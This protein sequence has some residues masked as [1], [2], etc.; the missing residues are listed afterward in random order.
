MRKSGLFYPTLLLVCWTGLVVAGTY[1]LVETTV[2]QHLALNYAKVRGRIIQSK[3]GEGGSIRRGIE[4][5]YAYVV[6]GIHYTG[7]RFRYDDHNATFEWDVTVDGFP[8]RSFETVYYN[9]NNPADAVLMP[10]IEGNDCLL[11]L[12]ALPLN[13]MT[14][15]LWRALVGRWR[16]VYRV[17]PVGGVRVFKQP[18]VT[19]VA[20][21]EI[22]A[23]GAAVYS[24][25]AA[26][27]LGVFPAV[28]GGGFDPSLRMMGIIWAFVVLAGVAAFIWRASSIRRGFYDLRNDDAAQTVTLP[29]IAGR[30]RLVSIPRRELRGVAIQRR[31]SKGPSGLRFSYLPALVQ[32]GL[33]PTVQSI[34][35]VT[36]GWS[37][38][39]AEAFSRWLSR[40]LGVEFKGIEE[41]DPAPANGH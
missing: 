6:S 32:G 5:E 35:L 33:N 17:P 25:G 1:A 4:L 16:D 20:M 34:K 38:K 14:G 39:R 41:E 8:R 3:V 27:F 10:G 12:F 9:P 37:E 15:V 23:A 7:H 13:I 19:R 29:Q 40:E 28:V 36:W 18:G 30:D 26:A 2:R 21:G 22:S 31:I 24:T 11:L